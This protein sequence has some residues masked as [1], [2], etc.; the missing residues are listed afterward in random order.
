M[1]LGN[2]DGSDGEATG[3]D[4]RAGAWKRSGKNDRAAERQGIGGVRLGGIDVDPFMASEWR[5]VKPR[6]ICKERVAT[7]MGNGGF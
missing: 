2:V 6:A 4:A 1:K 5:R 3:F 7:K